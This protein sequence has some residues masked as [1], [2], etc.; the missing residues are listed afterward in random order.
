MKL[1][2]VLRK[3]NNKKKRLK[4]FARKHNLKIGNILKYLLLVAAILGI[5][6]CFF[7]TDW[8]LVSSVE[9]VKP[10]NFIQSKDVEVLVD[11]NVVGK[12]I[13]FLDKEEIV[14]KIK[15]NF[16]AAK[17]VSLVRKYPSKIEI[18]LEERVPVAILENS[19]SEADYLVDSE[20]FI[21]GPVRENF[22]EY[23]SV[24]YEG[25]VIVGQFVDK[26]IVPVYL[27]LIESVNSKEMQ[28]SSMSINQRYSH[29]FLKG[30]AEVLIGNDKNLSDSLEIVKSILQKLTLEGKKTKEIDLRYEKVIVSYE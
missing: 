30:S 23:P 8:F 4:A 12:H 10:G 29:I 18:Y 16:L 1:Y 19:Y 27:D 14:Q 28:V 26:K 20:G 22:G 9:V 25:E 11:S 2:P 24:I 3:R 5:T 13:F 6:I 7:G 15:N 21:L 17:T